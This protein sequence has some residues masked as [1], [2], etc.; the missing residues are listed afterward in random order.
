MRKR[1]RNSRLI[2]MLLVPLVL[3]SCVQI[4]RTQAADEANAERNDTTIVEP[5]MTASE[6]SEEI[7]QKQAVPS[8]I[9]VPAEFE[10]LPQQIYD[11][12]EKG[13]EKS[14]HIWRVATPDSRQYVV[15]Q[16]VAKGTDTI[17]WTNSTSQQIDGKTV[18][19]LDSADNITFSSDFGQYA[20]NLPKDGNSVLYFSTDTTDCYVYGTIEVSELE[21]IVKRISIP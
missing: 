20:Y 15:A 4:T 6:T 8:A 19:I 11:L 16:W 1:T 2:S 13:G 14:R 21:Q 7:E 3:C 17:D 9:Y 18:Y 10:N 5:E 12:S